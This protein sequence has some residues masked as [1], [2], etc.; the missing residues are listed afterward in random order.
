MIQEAIQ[1]LLDELS[2]YISLNAFFVANNDGWINRITN[3]QNKE[4]ELFEIGDSPL[5]EVYCGLIINNE[6]K[7]I[8]IPELLK[9]P[10]TM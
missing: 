2:Q 9:H 6:K 5:E 10:L 7:P 3:V 8:V 4:I 1:E